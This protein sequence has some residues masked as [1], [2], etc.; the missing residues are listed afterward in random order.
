MSPR[1]VGSWGV[2]GEG[3]GESERRTVSVDG[4]GLVSLQSV[5]TS[6]TLMKLPVSSESQGQ[7]AGLAGRVFPELQ[8]VHQIWE[9]RRRRCCGGQGEAVKK[10]AARGVACASWAPAAGVTELWRGGDEVEWACLAPAPTQD[11]AH[12]G[13]D[14]VM[15]L[16]G[17]R[18]LCGCVRAS[19]RGIQGTPSF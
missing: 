19:G 5:R 13:A 9:E 17:R 7:E 14:S 18:P 2:G 11:G 15:V 4:T 3:D 6:P 1:D 10:P 12:T 16:E 8:S